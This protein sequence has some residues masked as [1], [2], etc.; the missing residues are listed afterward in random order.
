MKIEYFQAKRSPDNALD[1]SAVNSFLGRVKVKDIKFQ[2]DDKRI[3]IL[4]LYEE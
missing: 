2:S 1:M 4:V 3:E